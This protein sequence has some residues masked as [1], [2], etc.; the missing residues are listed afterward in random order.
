MAPHCEKLA[1]VTLRYGSH[2]CYTTNSSYPIRNGF[3]VKSDTSSHLVHSF[4][5]EVGACAAPIQATV[6]GD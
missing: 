5:G 3:I 6:C 1:S 2:S 4:T